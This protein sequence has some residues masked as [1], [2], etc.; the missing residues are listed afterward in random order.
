MPMLS[1]S[2]A[3]GGTWRPAFGTGDRGLTLVEVVLV[4]FLIG[5]MSTLVGRFDAV[6]EW[7]LKGD[8]RKF[9]ATWEFLY[10]QAIA[11]GEAYRLVLDL[12][13]NSYTVR[14]EIIPEGDVVKQV[15]Y[16]ENLRTRREQ[17]RRQEKEDE[18]LL[19][20]EEEIEQI[21]ARR[22][23]SLD[24][25]F[26]ETLYR[27]PYSAVKLGRPIEFPSLAERVQLSPGLSFE[28]V[29][30]TAGKVSE[31]RAQ[32]RF[33]PKGAAEFAVVHISQGEQEYTV[34]MNPSTGGVS[35]EDGY[36]EYEW[37][38]N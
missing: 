19:S 30:T 17:I 31:G 9:I 21:S 15:D 38:A 7:R 24:R 36:K 34:F 37:N 27:D 12:E 23:R 1:F 29:V 35:I 14:R 5:L 25:L 3:V 28:D 11:R 13:G 4:V 32:I 2:K 18:E 8:V 33:S 22:S 16:L 20:V 26:F 10:Q 6:V